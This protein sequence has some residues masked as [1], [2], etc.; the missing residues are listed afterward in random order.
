[1]TNGGH[2]GATG[3]SYSG[4]RRSANGS[5]A[6]GPGGVRA[7]RERERVVF[8]PLTSSEARGGDLARVGTGEGRGHLTILSFGF[9]HDFILNSFGVWFI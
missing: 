6:M 9:G 2:G 4:R 1:M 3:T 7:C 8:T 5:P